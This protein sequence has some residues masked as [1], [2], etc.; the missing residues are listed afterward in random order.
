MEAHTFTVGRIAH[1][2]DNARGQRNLLAAL[3]VFGA[4]IA[5][6]HVPAREVMLALAS[7]RVD[8]GVPQP[9]FAFDRALTDAEADETYA[10]LAATY[11]L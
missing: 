1:N 8:L 3:D 6:D 5:D 10:Y 4:L 9:A 7:V 2:P 11:G